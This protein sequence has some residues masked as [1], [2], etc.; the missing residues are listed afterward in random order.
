MTYSEKIYHLLEIRGITLRELAAGIGQDINNAHALANGKIKKPRKKTREALIK[1]LGLTMSQ[2]FDERIPLPF[3]EDRNPA[4]WNEIDDR[5]QEEIEA[6]SKL[7]PLE[8]DEASAAS[9][10]KPHATRT[11]TIADE[12]KRFA[13]QNQEQKEAIAAKDAE[14]AT[15]KATQRELEIRLD[16][17]RGEIKGLHE[18]IVTLKNQKST[19]GTSIP[20][21]EIS[22]LSLDQRNMTASRQPK[23]PRAPASRQTNQGISLSP[24]KHTLEGKFTKAV[25]PHHALFQIAEDALYDT[26]QSASNSLI[27]I[28]FSAFALEAMLNAFGRYCIKEENSWEAFERKQTVEKLEFIASELGIEDINKSKLFENIRWLIEFRNDAAHGKPDFSEHENRKWLKKNDVMSQ[29]ELGST[30]ENASKAVRTVQE[31]NDLFIAKVKECKR[32]GL[33]R[34]TAS[35]SFEGSAA[36]KVL[37]Q[38][39]KK[40]HALPQP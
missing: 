25:S 21:Q 15:L 16:E 33:D 35:I 1:F 37:K 30:I 7:A 32:A 28:V 40:T 23:E 29:T 27:S 26:S 22:L 36:F 34:N 3:E 4:R 19:S 10:A 12:I 20:I 9:Q 24:E 38:K 39:A 13:K 8:T 18:T 14:I 2:L 31:A 6:G 11:H 17:K 5:T